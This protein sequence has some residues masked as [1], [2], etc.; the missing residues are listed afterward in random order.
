MLL[1]NRS[2]RL[3]ALALAL[4]GCG[5]GG[6]GS[7]RSEPLE[8]QPSSYLN[9]K[10]VGLTPQNLPEAVAGN[11]TTR[12]FGDFA[13]E[14]RLDLITAT[15]TYSVVQPIASA[16]PSSLRY[17]RKTNS[18]YVE[19]SKRL[20]SASGCIHP[21]KSL[22]ADFNGDST[23]DVFLICH[24]YDAGAFPGEKNQLLLSQPDG[25]FSVSVATD[26]VGFWHGGTAFDINADGFVDVI[27]VTGG[28][29]PTV[30]LNDGSGGFQ[31]DTSARFAPMPGS[32]YYSLEA[33]D[34]DDDNDFDLIL[35]GHETEGSTAV[36]LN[37]GDGVFAQVV[38]TDL[39]SIAGWGV[40]LDFVATGDS[41]GTQLWVLRS[42]D[43]S[44]FYQGKLIQKIQWPSLS[45]AI[46]IED[47]NGAWLPWI[48]PTSLGS[49]PV[50]A[51][52]VAT[53]GFWVLR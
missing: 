51:P 6:V 13:R 27:A 14:G 16:T 32:G 40:V 28:N 7:P 23:P 52:D 15:L 47:T 36:L 19:D 24:G 46:A 34:V 18:G 4:A 21:R 2:L 17:W 50:I 25:S 38:P 33:V 11:G 43:G 9:F 31:T 5:G 30:W 10:G 20:R 37:P 44:N 29:T 3:G 12:A 53:D 35:G 1:F 39:P 26:D 45:S 41:G 49:K 8:V 42:Q 22:V 48:I